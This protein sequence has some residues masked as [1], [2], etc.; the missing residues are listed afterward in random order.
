MSLDFRDTTLPLE[1]RVRALLSELTVAE[2][3][4]LCAGRNFWETKPVPRVGLAAFRVTDG[5][6]GVAFH[7]TRKRGTAF[8]SGIALG[9]SFDPDLARR[10]G[11][12]LG[13]ETRAAGCS[14]VLGPAVNLC[15]TPLNGRTFEYFTEDPHLNARLAVACVE[16]IQGEGVAACVK[17]YAANNQETD[18]MRIDARVSQRALR[19][20]Y[21][22]AFEASVREA[23]AW[24]LMAAYNAVNGPAACEHRELLSD[25]L[26]DEWGFRGFVVSDWFAVRRA[27]SGEACL[28]AG[29]GLEMPGRGSRYREKNLRAELEAG[30]FEEADL[31]RALTGLLRVMFLTGHVDAPAK[32]VRGRIGRPEHEDLAR[33]MAEAGLT[34]LRNEDDLLPLDFSSVRKVAVVGPKAGA[35][36]CLPLWGGSSGVWPRREVTPRR[37]IEAAL[38]GRAQIVSDPAEADVAIVCVG[39][40]HRPGQDSEVADRKSL[41]LPRKQA[42][43]IR[44]TA[45]ANPRTVVVLIAGGPIAMD[46][47]PSAPVVL[48]AW[49]PGMEGGHAIGRAIAGDVNPSG[50]LPVSFPRHLA[51]SP[52]HASHR[53]YPGDRRQVHYDEGVFVGYRHFDRA[54]TEPLFPF[55]HSWEGEGSLGVSFILTNTGSRDGAE[56]AQLYLGDPESSVER[57]P[58]ELAV[59]A[60]H[61]LRA[62]ESTRVD[63]RISLR[64]LAWFDEER[65]GW[66][67]EAG[68][69]TVHVGASSRD[70]RL[71]GEFELLK[72]AFEPVG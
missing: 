6:R 71:E 13:R 52:A 19:E 67:A 69:Y 2:K 59:F 46:W 70:L 8:P 28:K 22:P 65:M 39:L 9:A 35:R 49:Y 3:L 41:E 37:G 4:S 62:G 29:L 56:V 72:D 54:G 32:R 17:H 61:A 48:M 5:P 50:K 42:D 57:P 60:K 10:F 47:L 25:V 53:T 38:R 15:R 40:S 51:D 64:D 20:L 31:D 34:L 43:L 1:D 58:R 27:T 7:S 30:R 26:R 55:G 11:Q 14:M 12:A 23:D 68:A 16:G 33:E 18:R 63:L 21:L 66:R 45:A 44:K 24:S 36:N